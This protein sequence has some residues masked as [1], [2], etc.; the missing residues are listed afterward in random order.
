MG[1]AVSIIW[2]GRP[3]QVETH[4]NLV[5]SI[6]HTAKDFWRT[7]PFNRTIGVGKH[8]QIIEVECQR[9]YE[10]K[11]AFPNYVIDGVVNGFEE[12]RTQPRTGPIGLAEVADNSVI[13]GIWTW[14]RGRCRS[15]AHR[16]LPAFRGAGDQLG[17]N[18]ALQGIQPGVPL[19]YQVCGKLSLSGVR[20]ERHGTPSPRSL[21]VS[22]VFR[23]GISPGP[24]MIANHSNGSAVLRREAHHSFPGPAPAHNAK[25]ATTATKAVQ[26]AIGGADSVCCSPSSQGRD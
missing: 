6:K 25:T 16:E 1:E 10:G 21:L 8:R 24:V 5:F 2:S 7:I 20:T 22:A 23:K 11:G 13:A 12:F 17:E 15:E 19:R 26:Y 4:E 14:S 18:V 3:F 9:E